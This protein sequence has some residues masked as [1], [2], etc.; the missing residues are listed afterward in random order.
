MWHDKLGHHLRLS[1][2]PGLQDQFPP[3]SFPQ[4]DASRKLGTL[5]LRRG[6]E[7]RAGHSYSGT[8]PF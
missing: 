8:Q 3:S 2:P 4:G 7:L 5:G 1:A 6:L